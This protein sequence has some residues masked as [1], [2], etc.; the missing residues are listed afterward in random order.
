MTHYYG[1]VRNSATGGSAFIDKN[2]VRRDDGRPMPQEQDVFVHQD[3]VQGVKLAE[4]I[5]LR[6]EMVPDERRA[7]GA[8]RAINVVG[9]RELVV[10]SS[11]SYALAD[12]ERL[13]VPPTAAQMHARPVSEAMVQKAVDNKPLSGMPRNTGA[14]V[15]DANAFLAKVFPQF[16]QLGEGEA[17]DRSVKNLI[18]Q[19]REMGMGSQ[20]AQTEK[21]LGVYAGLKTVL[22]TSD[23][24]LQPM[25]ILPISY[26]PDLFMA[27]PVWYRYASV[28]EHRS[29]QQQ[30]A[31][32]DPDVHPS[33]NYFCSLLPTQKWADT[34][35]MYNRRV[36]GIQDYVGDV[37]PLHVLDRIR[38]LGP[39]FD[40]LVIMTPYHDVAGQDW[41]N[42]SWMRS[43]DPYVVGFC[44]GVPYMF[45]IAR[46]SDSGVFP[47]YHELLAGTIQFLRDN[48]NALKGFNNVGSPYW[49]GPNTRGIFRGKLGDHLV[50]H[51]SELL[52]AFDAGRLFSWL[53]EEKP[54]VAKR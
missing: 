47:L 44:Q 10:A 25:S 31:A 6:F 3:D 51:V 9:T 20:A 35:Q 53:R 48:S 45:V 46:F 29:L 16:R 32:D 38:I 5:E 34:F 13:Y 7:P 49:A 50:R 43:I 23:D 17:F 18:A 26:L 41:Q 14:A 21:Q 2:S 33:T 27:V 15:E 54:P 52:G 1:N 24:L 30:R 42:V 11:H 22:K 37:I 4:G 28:A 12:P 40:H 8:F 39:H 36:R 19:Y